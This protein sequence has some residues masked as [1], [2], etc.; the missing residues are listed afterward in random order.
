VVCAAE[1]ALVLEA[2][3][4]E[5]IDSVVLPVADGGMVDPYG[6]QVVHIPEDNLHNSE[7]DIQ[8]AAGL[9]QDHVAVH[10]HKDSCYNHQVLAVAEDYSRKSSSGVFP[11]LPWLFPEFH[12]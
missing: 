5:G 2:L 3:W 10:F 11:L 8:A 9:D 4:K 12:Y 7:E 1:E 6:D